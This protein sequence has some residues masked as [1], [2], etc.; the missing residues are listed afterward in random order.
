MFIKAI[1]TDELGRKYFCYLN[2]NL[3]ESIFLDKKNLEKKLDYY[4]TVLTT[5]KEECYVYIENE[6]STEYQAI[7]KL[8]NNGC[9]DISSQLNKNIDSNVPESKLFV[10]F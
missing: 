10:A 8:I 7:R 5:S 6:A 1:K 2:S 3:I 9:I 4:F